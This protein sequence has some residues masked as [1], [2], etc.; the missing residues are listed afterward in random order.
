MGAGARISS[1]LAALCVAAVL[2]GCGG[3]ER[4]D[5]GEPSGRFPLQVS[6]ARFPREQSLAET[7]DLVLTARNAGDEQIPDL[8]VTIYTE[9]PPADGSFNVRLPDRGLANPSRPVWILE[10]GYPKKLPD[11]AKLSD[12]AQRGPGGTDAAQVNT[13]SFGALAPDQEVTMVWE[14]EPVMP[15]TFTVRYEMAADLQGEARA[16]TPSGDPVEGEFVATISDQPPRTRITDSGE[17][18]ETNS[19]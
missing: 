15:G 4:Q 5:E 14:V 3:G 6:E 9:E 11:G 10:E 13:Y 17:V 2:S 8:A 12:L 16:V 19:N 7:T 1:G 18:V